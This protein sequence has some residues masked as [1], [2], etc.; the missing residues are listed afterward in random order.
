VTEARL[1][2][3][4]AVTLL[5]AGPEHAGDLELALA[6]APVLIAA[7]GGAVRALELG[8]YPDAVIG[9]LDSLDPRTLER[10]GARRLHPVAEQETTD[11][12]KCLR[13]VDAPLYIGVG[14]IG[15]RLDHELAAMAE[16]VRRP[17]RRCVLIG[18]CDAVFAAPEALALELDPGTRVSLFPMA[19]IEGHSEGLRWPID[20]I[21][22]APDA[23][24]GT[25]NLAD[26]PVRLSF[27]RPG[28]LVVVPREALAAVLQALA[29]SPAAR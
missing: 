14:F 15:A 4:R 5:G 10:L 1:H 12:A 21:D 23:R 9:D 20:G 7:D 22:F 2:F 6:A 16:L 3:A 11:F 27:S 29:G 26:G 19:P 8:L 28:M 25:S 24:I 18:P 13:V 17:D